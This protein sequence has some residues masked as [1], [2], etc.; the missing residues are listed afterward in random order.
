MVPC[1]SHIP[2]W[3]NPVMKAKEWC[4]GLSGWSS[5]TTSCPSLSLKTHIPAIVKCGT[6]IS[7]HLTN[8]L[9]YREHNDDGG[10]MATKGMCDFRCWFALGKTC[11]CMCGGVNHGVGQHQH[12]DDP[13][14]NDMM[15]D[16]DYRKYGFNMEQYELHRRLMIKEGRLN[17]EPKSDQV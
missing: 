14:F 11:R 2:L 15:K 10:N 4:S 13:V 7:I 3:D 6:L 9:L 5:N 17:G 1:V 16:A 8:V 12:P